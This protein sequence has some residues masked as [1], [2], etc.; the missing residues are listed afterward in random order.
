MNTNTGITNYIYEFLGLEDLENLSK[1]NKE[2]NYDIN[3]SFRDKIFQSKIINIPII[4]SSLHW[5]CSNNS[6]PKR[7]LWNKTDFTPEQKARINIHMLDNLCDYEYPRYGVECLIFSLH[8]NGLMCQLPSSCHVIRE[9]PKSSGLIEFS[10]IRNFVLSSEV[11]TGYSDEL[12]E[13]WDTAF[14][15]SKIKIIN[16]NDEVNLDNFPELRQVV[17]LMEEFYI[18]R[19][20]KIKITNEIRFN[21]NN[22]IDYVNIIDDQ[23]NSHVNSNY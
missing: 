11:A 3:K 14:K 4:Q 18:G 21:N 19:E 1:V 12:T 5:M 6:E 2:F 20:G 22:Y 16:N 9:Y 17:Q 10:F 8:Q 13:D 15:Y 7:Y 23:T